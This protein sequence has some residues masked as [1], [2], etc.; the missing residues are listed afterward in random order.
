MYFYFKCFKWLSRWTRSAKHALHITGFSPLPTFFLFTHRIFQ[1]SIRYP[2]PDVFILTSKETIR[3]PEAQL[4]VKQTCDL[5]SGSKVRVC[6]RQKWCAI[7]N[8]SLLTESVMA[9][10]VVF[11]KFK[12]VGMSLLLILL[13]SFKIKKSLALLPFMSSFQSIYSCHQHKKSF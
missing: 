13:F 4:F 5:R 6:L 11:H 2:N 3:T 12:Y 10:V 1:E 8:F 9:R 7:R